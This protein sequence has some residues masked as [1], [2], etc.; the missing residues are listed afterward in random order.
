M[1]HLDGV[2]F[3]YDEI[4]GGSN[5]P[6][7]YSAS[8]WNGK[9]ILSARDE[10]YQK[11]PQ[12]YPSY[13]KPSGKPMISPDRNPH[14]QKKEGFGYYRGSG[15]SRCRHC[16]NRGNNGADIVLLIM[17][18]VMTAIILTMGIKSYIEFQIF[19]DTVLAKLNNN[20]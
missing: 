12:T 16:S 18:I 19:K 9:P 13:D 4:A 1:A 10:Y 17:L 8:D 3:G 2:S 5:I 6:L 15:P 20:I 14:E 7:I 11:K